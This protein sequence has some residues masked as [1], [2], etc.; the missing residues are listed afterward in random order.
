MITTQVRI[1]VN[2][3]K[4]TDKSFR[5]VNL[6]DATGMVAGIH[7][8]AVQAIVEVWGHDGWRDDVLYFHQESGQWSRVGNY[9]DETYA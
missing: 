1:A 2:G 5:G 6:V 9:C 4:V 3:T 8:E 7:G